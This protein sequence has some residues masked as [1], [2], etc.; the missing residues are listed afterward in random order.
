MLSARALVSRRCCTTGLSAPS[1][2]RASCRRFSTCGDPLT[3]LWSCGGTLGRPSQRSWSTR[4]S[5]SSSSALLLRGLRRSFQASIGSWCSR[6]R[7]KC[8]CMHSASTRRL[9]VC[10]PRFARSTSWPRTTSWSAPSLQTAPLGAY[11]L[12][13]TMGAYT[14]SSTSTMSPLGPAGQRDAVQSPCRR[15]SWP[16][17]QCFCARCLKRFSDLPIAWCS[18]SSTAFETSCCRS[19]VL[20]PSRCSDFRGPSLVQ[21]V[22][23]RSLRRSSCAPLNRPS[24]HTRFQR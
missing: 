9:A 2:S 15:M 10:C 6:R 5:P 8:R 4:V 7:S 19:R 13:A 14:S 17:C 12:A 22:V 24:C 23:S 21:M 1:C 3:R 11:F 20:L 16:R 18:W